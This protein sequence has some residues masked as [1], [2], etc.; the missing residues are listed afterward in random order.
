MLLG[1]Q[2]SDG[3]QPRRAAG[4][5]LGRDHVRMEWGGVHGGSGARSGAAGMA[6]RGGPA[7]ASRA[8]SRTR[9]PMTFRRGPSCG[10]SPPS[11]RRRCRCPF[12]RRAAGTWRRRFGRSLTMPRPSLLVCRS[13]AADEKENGRGEQCRAAER[14]RREVRPLDGPAPSGMPIDLM[15]SAKHAAAGCADVAGVMT[16]R[17]TD[18]FD[19]T[20]KTSGTLPPPSPADGRIRLRELA[21][22]AYRQGWIGPAEEP[23]RQADH[24]STGAVCFDG[25]DKS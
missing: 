21:K 13:F 6:L 4:P 17:R 2:A 9:P 10:F 8:C 7:G 20:T 16:D 24:V 19:I 5:V 22:R 1:H 3:G 12:S 25:N 11:N 23:P 18:R 14:R 15:E